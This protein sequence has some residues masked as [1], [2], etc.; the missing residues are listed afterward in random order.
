[1]RRSQVSVRLDLARHEN[2]LS[3]TKK[4]SIVRGAAGSHFRI[5]LRPTLSAA[6][7][8][9]DCRDHFPPN[10]GPGPSSKFERTKLYARSL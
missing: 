3:S 5:N 2:S 9:I 10:L 1:M 4:C 7:A 8:L 6:V